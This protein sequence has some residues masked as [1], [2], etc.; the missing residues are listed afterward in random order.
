M[1]QG[2]RKARQ[3]KPNSKYVSHS[4]IGEHLKQAETRT[5]SYPPFQDIGPQTHL[6]G[7]GRG[8]LTTKG[9]FINDVI[10]CQKSFEENGRKYSAAQE[11]RIQD[12]T[13]RCP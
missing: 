12:A 6:L 9:L 7:V 4:P 3:G 11:I 8:N 13:T 10:A 5:V 2:S 1:S